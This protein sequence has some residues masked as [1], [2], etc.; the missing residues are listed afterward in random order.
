M[1]PR[2]IAIAT[3]LGRCSFPPAT[4]AKRFARD[5]AALAASAPHHVLTPRQ[6]AYLLRLAHRFRRQ[7]TAR[8][9]ELVLDEAECLV[10][11]HP[12]AFG[13]KAPS[14]RKITVGMRARAD[15]QLGLAL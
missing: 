11:H 3:A 1:S 5:T 4:A 12:E 8:I 7:L 6:V 14:P 2:Q 15:R 10:Q 9:S 13:P